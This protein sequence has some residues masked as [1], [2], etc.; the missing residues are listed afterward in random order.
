MQTI[1]IWLVAALA[2]GSFWVWYSGWRPPLTPS[3]IN[4]F[5]ARIE[6]IQQYRDDLAIKARL[7][8]FLEKDDGG[9][10]YMVNLIRMR[11]KAL[12]IEGA[13]PDET[14]R[15]VLDHYATKFMPTI[16]ARAGWLVTGG[17]AAAS[18][19]LE[20]WGVKPDAYWMMFGLVRY[21][22]R[23]D[24]MEVVTNPQFDTIHPFKFA[25][26]EATRAFPVAPAILTLGPKVVA[27]LV[28]LV[29]ALSAQ[30]LAG[31]LMGRT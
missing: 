18:G 23:R 5:M 26:M 31:N 17:R 29:L 16:L 22:S 7:R 10:F 11:D 2:Y 1:S 24:M 25:S 12:P 27:G 14:P 20:Q 4:G 15:Q 28:V 6:H 3:E 21:R 30:L 19:D 8:A 9:E 13:R